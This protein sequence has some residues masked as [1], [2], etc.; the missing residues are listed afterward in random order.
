MRVE[1]ENEAL[2]TGQPQLGVV[3]KPSGDLDCEVR[4]TGHVPILDVAV[5]RRLSEQQLA[6][7]GRLDLRLSLPDECLTYLP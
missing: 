6:W 7:E 2:I 1:Y 5:A 3:I 4:C